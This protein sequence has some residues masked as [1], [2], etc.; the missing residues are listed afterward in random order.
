MNTLLEHQV[1]V[2]LLLADFSELEALARLQ[3]SRAG[4]RSTAIQ[5][6]DKDMIHLGF[7]WIWTLTFLELQATPALTVSFASIHP[8]FIT[9]HPERK[10]LGCWRLSQLYWSELN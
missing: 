6:Q 10:V 5:R 8:L 9:S 1:L 4:D 7:L 2:F 3:E